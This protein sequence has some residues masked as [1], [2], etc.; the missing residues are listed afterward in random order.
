MTLSPATAVAFALSGDTP[1]DAREWITV[2]LAGHPSPYRR[3]FVVMAESLTPS[4]RGQELA[5][6]ARELIMQELRRHQKQP[7]D[8]ALSRAFAVANSVVFDEGRFSGGVGQQFLIGATA[9]V[10]EQHR[11]TI[12]HV[13]PG[14]FILAQDGIVYGIPDIES[15][16]PHYSAPPDDAP[17][18]EPL[19]Y[20][21]WTSPMLVQTELRAGDTMVLC[22]A[23]TGKLLSGVVQEAGGTGFPIRQIHGRDPEKIMD[24]IR[25]VVLEH[26]LPAAVVAVISF[27]PIATGA[28]ITTVSDIGRNI[29]EQWRHGRAA[30]QQFR[31]VKLPVRDDA[32]EP[33][34]QE[35]GTA[36][37]IV[38]DDED[39]VKVVAATRPR[40]ESLQDRLIR[41]TERR[42]SNYR[43]TWRTP[44]ESR[45][46][47]AP[48]AHGVSVYRARSVSAGEPSWRHAFPR[49]PFL[50]SPI[51]IGFCLALLLG[52][53]VFGYLEADRFLTSE[54]DYQER[55]AEVDQRLVGLPDLD[56]TDAI[57]I[58]LEE[59]E[60]LL[61]EAEQ[62]GAPESV[63]W[64]RENQIVIERDQV[65]R[66]VRM[67]E[68]TR[69]GSLPE[70]LQLSNTRAVQTSGGIFLANG[71]LYRLDPENREMQLVLPMGSEVEGT[72][73]GDLY[74]VAYD[75]ELLVVTD[76]A[77]VFFAGSA[78]GAAWHAMQMEEINEQGSWPAGPI[79]VFT[80]NL[81]I[82]VS[83]Y[84]NIYS[85]VLDPEETST[86]PTDWA[87]TGDRVNLNQAID[88]T[89]DGNIYVLLDDGRVLT[90]YRGSQIA[91]FQ[92]PGFDPETD[93]P[94]AVVGGP[95]TG[96]L[97]VAVVSDD[98]PGRVIAIDR[99]GGTMSQLALPAGFS[100]G[101]ADVMS[102][103]ENLQ[104]IAVDEAS[105]TLYMING[106]A[107][108]TARYSLPPL[109]TPEG[110]PVASP[111]AVPDE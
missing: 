62:A 47:G 102:P 16:L 106:D 77:H 15:W 63:V 57:L 30:V 93:T 108:W 58:E 72:A 40:R 46:L 6:H 28:Q 13:P 4:G 98:G 76:G 43:D 48:G 22:N 94:L 52:V 86:A 81:Y 66:I 107:V 10:F 9:I 110:T 32:K 75:G 39:Y 89:I 59:A 101:D 87:L 64:P 36:A 99:E 71:S 24:A 100:T 70:E 109:P 26:D 65:M 78:D 90:M 60:A 73:V 5:R 56:D 11:A 7:A 54:K 104:D 31:P 14:Q 83:E 82:L 8:A 29:R 38:V 12:A 96:Y 51:F 45:K 55:I 34:E 85:F 68:L 88:M 95:R 80:Q 91:S 27:P 92:L 17:T 3:G 49:M 41:L 25:D 105:G 23:A 35:A 53:V 44:S 67:D 2:D 21:S 50:R 74:G 69:I 18:P 33:S 111:E 103:F 1:T 97:Y 79:S 42:S 84:R 20:A 61:E 37:S 19:G